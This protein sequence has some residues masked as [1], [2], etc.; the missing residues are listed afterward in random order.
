LFYLNKTR[1]DF[2]YKDIFDKARQ[3]LGI[4]VFYSIVDIPS[5]SYYRAIT[6]RVPDYQ[7]RFFYI[8]GPPS[9]VAAFETNLRK[10]GVK[11]SHIKADYFP[12][13]A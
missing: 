9:M 7:E 8:S 1:D 3:E 6:E 4:K 11:K 2:A 12:G 5:A 13:F 10:I